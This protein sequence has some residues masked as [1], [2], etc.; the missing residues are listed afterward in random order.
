VPNI[1][2]RDKQLTVLNALVEGNSVRSAE[3]M[4]GVHR[5]TILRLMVRVG[6]GCANLLDEM[7]RDLTCSRLELDELWSF[8]AK[9]QR[10]VLPEDDPSYGDVWT[11]IAIDP[12]S[13]L[14][15][16]FLVGKRD[17]ANTNAFV[18]D[19]ASRLRYRVQLSS[20]AMPAYKNA[21]AS[22]FKGNVDYAA[23]VKA[24][25][26]EPA[27]AGRYS[28]PRVT[29]IEKIPVFGEPVAELVCTSY[30]ENRNLHLRMGV[31]RYTRLVNAHSKKWENHAAMTA[32]HFAH[33]NLA[34]MHST[35][36]CT[37]AMA[38]GVT[39]TVWSMPE[40]LDA[41]TEKAA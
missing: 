16:S 21:I 12:E 6:N 20:D 9:K 37:P 3:R 38:A 30:V 35:I 32:L 17:V 39:R 25:E 24:Y 4:T 29:S 26:A 34:K 22:A 10:R 13:K 19:L 8:I 41:A 31:R 36:R 40:L 18:A 11:Y 5:D 7:M 2:P 14:I 33:Y 23:L 28:P 27:G 15:P 1:L